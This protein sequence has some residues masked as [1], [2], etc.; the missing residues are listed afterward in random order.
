MAAIH[1]TKALF[2]T[3]VARA[4]ALVNLVPPMDNLKAPMVALIE[5]GARTTV[6]IMNDVPLID[7]INKCPLEA[8]KYIRPAAKGE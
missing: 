5:A 3:G 1:P 8:I 2:T 6:P 7:K 4:L